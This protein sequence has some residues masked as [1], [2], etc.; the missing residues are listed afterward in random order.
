MIKGLYTS[1]SDILPRVKK[2][3][4][5]ANN[6]ASA[7]TNDFKKE[8]LFTK[9]LGKTELKR[10]NTKSYW[11]RPIATSTGDIESTPVIKSHSDVHIVFAGGLFKVTSQ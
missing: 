11:E 4:M 5:T 9:E 8:R 6:V 3:E 2:Q 7:E 10:I 1:A